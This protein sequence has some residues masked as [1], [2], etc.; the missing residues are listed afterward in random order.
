MSLDDL[1]AEQR[2]AVLAPED[3]VLVL[4]NGRIGRTFEKDQIDAERIR[5]ALRD[6]NNV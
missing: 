1:N 5:E 6:E 3:R 4:E 2:A